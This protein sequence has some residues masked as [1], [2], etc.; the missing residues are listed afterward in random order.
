MNLQFVEHTLDPWFD[1]Q[2][3]ILILGTIPS[4]KSREYRCYYGHPQNR[5]W[6]TLGAVFNENVPE[7]SDDRR[8]FVSRHRIALWDVLASCDIRGAEDASISSPIPNNIP[9]L[10][11]NSNIEYVFTTGQKAK[12]LYDKLIKPSVQLEAVA[13]PSTSPANRRW[14]TDEEL[15]KAYR[16]LSLL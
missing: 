7:S 12:K 11:Q 14:C 4:P 8:Q 13:L 2:S 5:F 16:I 10:L 1:E 9:S 15:I 6:R 3:R